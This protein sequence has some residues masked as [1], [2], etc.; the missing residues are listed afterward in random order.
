MKRGF[1][2]LEQQLIEEGKRI[3]PVFDK[4]KSLIEDGADVNS[5]SDDLADENET[6]LSLIIQG[7]SQDYIDGDGRYLADVCRFFLENGYQVQ[8]NQGGHGGMC[9]LNLS[10]ASYDH[11]VLDAAEVLLAAGAD[12]LYVTDDGISV[13][14]WI[15]SKIGKSYL[16][17]DDDDA[18]LFKKLYDLIKNASKA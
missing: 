6:P 2:K 11:Y 3:P 10:W 7:Y 12:P 18:K 15:A 4:M 16:C 8:A 9:L 13:L 1:S 14:G 5:L 17:K